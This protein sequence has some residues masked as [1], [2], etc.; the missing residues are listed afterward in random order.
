MRAISLYIESPSYGAF[1]IMYP[2]NVIVVKL[3]SKFRIAFLHLSSAWKT[4]NCLK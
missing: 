1:T 4:L 3:T 2:N